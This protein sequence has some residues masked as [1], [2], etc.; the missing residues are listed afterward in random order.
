MKLKKF[1]LLIV[2]FIFFVRGT[3]QIQCF[4]TELSLIA[5][6]DCGP[7]AIFQYSQAVGYDVIGA[8]EG[9]YQATD[10]FGN[11]YSGE[12]SGGEILI[13]N[14]DIG[15][16]SLVVSSAAQR[17]ETRFAVVPDLEYRRDS[18]L[19][20]LAFS[21]MAT[22]TYTT[23]NVTDYDAYAKTIA[24][25]GVNYVREFINW[26]DLVANNRHLKKTKALI[27]AYNANGIDVMLMIQDMPGENARNTAY[28]EKGNCI[29]YDM[30]I[31]YSAI[32]ELLN[33][34]S[35][36]I[37]AIEV[38]NEPD[39]LTEMDTADRY[40]SLLKVA[41]IAAAEMDDSVKIST[42]GIAK[43]NS[44]FAQRLLQNDIGG[45]IDIYDTHLYRNYTADE[46]YIET[47]EG[48]NNFMGP[49]TYYGLGNKQMWM[50]E[51]GF[52]SKFDDS[53]NS[54]LSDE[55]VMQAA[56]T[57]PI[58][59]IRADKSGVDK[60]FWFIH[61]YLKEDGVNG[62]GTLN[63]THTPNYVYS[64]LSAFTNALGNAGYS[65]EIETDGANICIYAEGTQEIACVWSDTVKNI[66]LP[67]NN[68]N[69]VITDI[70]GRETVV[71]AENNTIEFMVGP[72]IQ[73]IRAENGFADKS[74]ELVQYEKEPERP[75]FT[76]AQ[77]VVMT[78][79]FED[80]TSA[81]AASRAY[82]LDAGNGQSTAVRLQLYNFNDNS[83]NVSVECVS[84]G[85]WTIDNP[86]QMISVPSKTANQG[87][88]ATLTYN[89]SANEKAD[90]YN[91]TPLVF[92]ATV[93]GKKVPDV[94]TYITSN[95]VNSTKISGA[96]TVDRW[97]LAKAGTENNTSF[98]AISQSE[99]DIKM[100]CT[101]ES[102]TKNKACRIE[103]SG[104]FVIDNDSAGI[105]F[106]CT[107][108][109]EPET[110]LRVWLTDSDNDTFYSSYTVSLSDVAQSGNDYTYVF[111]FENFKWG[112]GT[113]NK[114]FDTGNVKIKIGIMN[115]TVNSAEFLFKDFGVV[116]KVYDTVDEITVSDGAYKDGLL[117]AKLSSDRAKSVKILM[118]GNVFDGIVLQS[119]ISVN[120]L[121]PEG[122]HSA[123]ILIY[124]VANRVYKT[125]ADIT[126]AED[127]M[128]IFPETPTEEDGGFVTDDG[129]VTVKG[130]T[131]IS[132]AGS[133][134]TIIVYP[135]NMIAE[136]ISLSD[137]VYM[138]EIQV[139]SQGKYNF[140]FVIQNYSTDTEYAYTL[141][142]NGQ[143]VRS[144]VE[145]CDISYDWQG[146][147]I[148]FF[149]TEK[150]LK[151]VVAMEQT[152]V[153]LQFITAMYDKNNR[154]VNSLFEDVAE[155]TSIQKNEF[156]Y[157]IPA[158]V[159]KISTYVWSSDGN[160]IPLQ[161]PYISYR[162]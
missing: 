75:S 122:T 53:A 55:Q 42:A 103:Y 97:S 44:I 2:S 107:S 36:K 85:G 144:T 140:D 73:Y 3:S 90:I 146:A 43:C 30:N 5:K 38:L 76:V 47:P 134:A 48:I 160:I 108:P 64:A 96:E 68:G 123:E 109:Q 111:P 49:A 13:K 119:D 40:A 57:A 155:N 6:A 51:Y 17:I 80:E 72:D 63:S 138:D 84:E 135:A 98:A 77:K 20:P 116:Q 50:S 59:L 82:S 152:P 125:T 162:N 7:Y 1:I 34:F 31:A 69:V 23:N 12:F 149:R 9:V 161:I 92:S 132:Y 121:L 157:S 131:N 19:N 110:M 58:A 29:T 150:T 137:I 45:Y 8:S 106:K 25:A 139:D 4:A 52:R 83:V 141:N 128:P 126:V 159:S 158:D 156:E 16:Y 129:N 86:S 130:T 118:L 61:G 81:M 136:D 41:S 87:G 127:D 15:H 70:M 143:P 99:S 27:D 26:K 88:L 105:S 46:T 74:E 35:G 37:D 148:R 32:K 28:Y 66:T 18:S 71:N 124:D 14:L 24:L 79:E 114:T 100:S 54:D 91:N 133:D 151:V 10:Y 95:E 94:V 112:Y 104:D 60:M 93:N 22:Y 62:Y 78:A 102:A 67:V 120:A 115:P 101:F 145:E 33:N 142:I 89:I 65:R 39:D 113:G 11:T 153:D 56:R 147:K 21:A 154:M 117:T